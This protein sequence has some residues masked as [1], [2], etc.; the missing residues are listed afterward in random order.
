[1]SRFPEPHWLMGVKY[2]VL[3]T[4]SIQAVILSRRPCRQRT[5]IT[6]VI[7]CFSFIPLSLCDLPSVTAQIASACLRALSSNL[8][9]PVVQ[10]YCLVLNLT[11]YVYS[12]HKKMIVTVVTE[13]EARHGFSL[14]EC[15]EV[16]EESV[17]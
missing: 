12:C 9:V 15:S 6:S 2:L 16:K 11:L 17:L 10:T 14:I 5:T 8:F 4:N 7:T 13:H 3:P 1:M